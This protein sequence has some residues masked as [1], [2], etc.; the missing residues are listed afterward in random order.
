M[1]ELHYRLLN[2]LDWPSVQALCAQEGGDHWS[3]PQWASSLSGDWVMGAF[4]GNSLVAVLVLQSGYLQAEVLNLLVD[5]QWRRRGIAQA[6]LEQ[7]R[8]QAQLWQA[9]KLLLELRYSNHAALNLYLKSGWRLDGRRRD[10]YPRLE[11][12]GRED[13]WLMSLP[14]AGQAE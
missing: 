2:G 1:S 5:P 12:Q 3:Q 7:A 11:G 9:E 6:L 13:A 14:L 4:A 8:C 10:Y